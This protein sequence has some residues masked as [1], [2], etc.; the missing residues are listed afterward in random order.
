MTDELN[1]YKVITGILNNC[2]AV[3]ELLNNNSLGLK[4]SRIRNHIRKMS[5]KQETA[6]Y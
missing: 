5:Y 6:I 3:T 2:R 1:K 4:L